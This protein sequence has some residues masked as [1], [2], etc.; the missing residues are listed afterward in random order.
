MEVKKISH[1]YDPTQIHTDNIVLILGFF[2]GIHQGHK[3]VIEKGVQ[4]AKE[5]GLK[6]VVMTFNRHPALV[7]QRFDPLDLAYL[8]T[9]SRKEKLIEDLE[10]DLLYEVGFTSSLGSLSPEEFVEQYIIDWNAK[11]VVAGFDYT[12][13]K[14]EVANMEK[15]PEY[16]EG[17]FEVVAVEKQTDSKEKIS[18][19]RIR[20]AISDGDM[21][22][23]NELLGYYFETSGYVIHGDARG[24]EL[25]YPTANVSQYPYEFLPKIGVYAVMFEVH[26]QWHKGMASIGYNVTFGK[27]NYYSI[28]VNI[29][30]FNKEIYGEDVRIK[31][32]E[33]LRDEIYFD[34]INELIQQL[35]QDK[36][37][38]NNIL[39]NLDEAKMI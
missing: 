23:A 5:R 10:V 20:Q 32:I 39:D 22:K 36:I 2:D 38:T 14:K 37:D 27:R 1:P 29:F 33:F 19:T 9:N 8:T 3:A 15:L 34:T 4:I 35:D 18:S 31:W 25:G 21:K 24:R 17:R 11:V 28:E 30:D 7:Y 6:S 12:Y 16:A 26:G 13:G